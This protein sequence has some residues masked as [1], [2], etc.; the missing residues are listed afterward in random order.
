MKIVLKPLMAATAVGAMLASDAVTAKDKDREENKSPF[1]AY[2]GKLPDNDNLNNS[3]E[4]KVPGVQSRPALHLPDPRE[5]D[6][7]RA[8]PGT[9]DDPARGWWGL[10]LL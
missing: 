2:I 7:Q 8:V 3:D 9:D 6:R 10:S 4:K 5:I 1:K